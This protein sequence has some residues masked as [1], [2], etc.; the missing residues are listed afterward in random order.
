ML[1]QVIETLGIFVWTQPSEIELEGWDELNGVLDDHSTRLRNTGDFLWQTRSTLVE[2]SLFQPFQ[3][4]AQICEGTAYFSLHRS[5][6]S[7]IIGVVTRPVKAF[8]SKAFASKPLR[9]YVSF[10]TTRE[11]LGAPFSDLTLLYKYFAASSRTWGTRADFL[12]RDQKSTENREPNACKSLKTETSSLLQRRRRSWTLT[13]DAAGVAN[14]RKPALFVHQI[15]LPSPRLCC[16]PIIQ[17]AADPSF[18]QTSIP[19]R[20]SHARPIQ[21]KAL[22]LIH[23]SASYDGSLH[24]LSGI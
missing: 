14:P 13:K 6:G 1:C 5:Q 8:A 20:P 11:F 19:L 2:I 17:T 22:V 3:R 21:K 12:G 18:K 9:R 7:S 24:N 4:L 15:T 10:P 16:P 23:L